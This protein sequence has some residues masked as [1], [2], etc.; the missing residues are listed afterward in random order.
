MFWRIMLYARQSETAGVLL[1]RRRFCVVEGHNRALNMDLPTY[2]CGYFQQNAAIIGERQSRFV[3][4]LGGGS[5]PERAPASGSCRPATSFRPCTPIRHYLNLTRALCRARWMIPTA[6]LGIS[7]EMPA[8]LAKISRIMRDRP[9]WACSVLF[10]R[11]HDR[12]FCPRYPPISD[13]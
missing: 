5:G 11:K 2:R 8:T 6:I 9:E 3:I 13:R 10:P 7:L 12:Q 1:R 4:E